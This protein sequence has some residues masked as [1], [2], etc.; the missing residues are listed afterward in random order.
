MRLFLKFLLHL[1][2]AC[3][4][5]FIALVYAYAISKNIEWME[6]NGK[7][8]PWN[9]LG[10]LSAGFLALLFAKWAGSDL[11]VFFDHVLPAEKNGSNDDDF[12]RGEL[13]KRKNGL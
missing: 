4:S 8:L 9:A 2:Y 3:F 10:F 12:P 1:S 7:Y 11:I 13:M 5:G 6:T